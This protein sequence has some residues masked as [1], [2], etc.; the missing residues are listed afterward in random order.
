[1]GSYTIIENRIIDN[2]VRFIRIDIDKNCIAET[3]REVF[4]SLANLSWLN[5]FDESYIKNS[6]S[7]RAN[8]TVDYI[9]TNI[10]RKTDDC[11]T[12]DSGEYVVS[13]LSRKAIV[14]ELSYLDIPLGEL[15]KEQKSG[16]PGFDFFSENLN[17]LILF[18]EAKYHRKKQMHTEAR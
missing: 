18:G 12:S 9:T 1:M 7:V 16:N 2:N 11:V 4:T 15:I 5:N 3:L 14:S 8:S 17:N 6:F 13:E 10:I